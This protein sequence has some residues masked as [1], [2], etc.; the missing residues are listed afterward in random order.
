M[1]LLF[2]KGVCPS[3]DSDWTLPVAV[4]ATF[5]EVRK[6]AYTWAASS[7]VDTATGVTELS[8][9]EIPT[10]QKYFNQPAW[11]PTVHT[12]ATVV[13]GSDCWKM[14]QRLRLPEQVS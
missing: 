9:Q 2:T 10:T 5:T 3:T 4:A 14:N 12:L 1:F 8:A 13:V 6:F 7:K 11:E